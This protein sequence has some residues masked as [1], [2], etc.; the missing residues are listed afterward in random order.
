MKRSGALSRAARVG[1]V[2][3]SLGAFGAMP[4]GPAIAQSAPPPPA[5]PAPARPPDPALEAARTAFDAL[6]EVERKGIQDALVWTG[7]QF[8]TVDG[9]FG[10]QTY[11]GLLAYQRRMKLP[12]DGLL[13]GKARAALVAEGQRLR[14][15][16]GFTLLDDDKTGARI[17]IP[18][19]VLPKRDV[20]PNGGSRWQSGD[21]KITVDTRAVPAGE[22]TLQSLFERNVAIQSPGRQVTYKVLRPEFFVVSGETASGK[23]YTRYAG[24]PDGL[25][26]LSVGYDKSLGRD[27]DKLVIAIANSFLAFPSA[28]APAVAAAPN[29]QPPVQAAPPKPAG[30]VLLGSGLVVGPRRVVT[31]AAVESCPN[32]RVA[33]RRPS[34]VRPGGTGVSVLDMEDVLK[35]VPVRLR[36]E[37][38]GPET[39][40]LVLSYGMAGDAPQLLAAPGAVNGRTIS[41]PLQA[42]ASGAAVF[43]RSGSLVG[44]VARVAEGRRDI[45]GTVPTADYGLVPAASFGEVL[46]NRHDGAVTISAGSAGE[47]AAALRAAVVPVVCAP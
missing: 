5:A 41:S 25:R 22:A 37:P 43:D 47:L 2:F 1:A 33:G 35:A 44:I 14:Q 38:A 42:G 26:G 32:L 18:T 13:D 3:A 20:N 15:A 9:S 39:P 30:P 40:V 16:A 8:G 23:F 6:P 11:E 12:P 7:D 45:A 21:G 4:A 24:G 31:T 17:G 29:P 27:V 10:R 36:A 28:A 34:Q 19:K 46:Q